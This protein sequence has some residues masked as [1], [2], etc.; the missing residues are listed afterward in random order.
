M[1]IGTW[2]SHNTKPFIHFFLGGLIIVFIAKSCN[3]GDANYKKAIDKNKSIIQRER[4]LLKEE[5][6]C[7][8]QEINSSKEYDQII[9]I[10]DEKYKIKY[11][12]L[13]KQYQ[14]LQSELVAIR[15]IVL[16]YAALD[17]LSGVVQ[18]PKE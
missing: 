15:T 17:S 11:F 4:D 8:Q 1:K 5:L 6:L 3:G 10:T 2:L 14:G 12:E 16:P 7:L 9:T 13:L 18:Y